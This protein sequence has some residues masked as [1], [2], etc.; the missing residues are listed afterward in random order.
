M[1]MSYDF[2]KADKVMDFFSAISQ[3]TIKITYA[4]YV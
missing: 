2:Y 3:I 4:F 1:D